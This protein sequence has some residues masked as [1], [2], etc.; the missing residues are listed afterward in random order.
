MLIKTREWRYGKMCYHDKYL[1]I[2]L[3]YKTWP[4]DKLIS[5]FHDDTISFKDNKRY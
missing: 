4:Y 5:S 2:H 1:V 3:H